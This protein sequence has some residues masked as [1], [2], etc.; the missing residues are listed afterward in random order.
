MQKLFDEDTIAAISTAV[1]ESGIG[2]IKISGPDALKIADKV[3]RSPGGKKRLA[4]VPT[5]T[6]HYGYIVEPESEQ[7]IDEIL[8]SVMLA[9]KTYTA[10]D[11]VEINCHGGVLV[12]TKVLDAV[13]KAGARP[14]EPGEFTKRAFLNGR[15]DLTGAEAV[16]DV[17]E[18]KNQFALQ[19]SVSQVRGSLYSKIEQIRGEMIYQSAHIEACLDN[20]DAMS[21]DDYLD[22]FSEKV[23][24]WTSDLSHLL[25]TSDSGRLMQEG[26]RTVIVGKPNAGKSSLLNLLLGEDRAIVT[27]IA[28]TTRDVLTETVTIGGMTLN[29][30]DTAGIRDTEDIVEKIGVQRARE[31]VE[32]ADLILYLI[33][34]STYIDMEDREIMDLIRGKKVIILQNKTDLDTVTDIESIRKAL[35]NSNTEDKDN[36]SKYNDISVIPFSAKEKTGLDQLIDTLKNLFFGGKLSFNDQIVIT[37]ARHKTLLA[38]ALESLRQLQKSI[39][40]VMPEDFYTVDLMSAYESLGEI[41]GQEIGDDLADE[42]FSRFCMGK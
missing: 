24:A 34:S 21:F 22:E 3:Y 41:T 23:K 33:D 10:E 38:K 6:I 17:I 37:N 42:I 11:V 2:I 13:I 8:V 18:S 15:I 7:I 1:S 39:D 36:I 9:P 30:T 16:M 32:K 29:I 5:H 35:Q 19:N 4:H 31:A 26:I 20:P 25:S 40:D 28:G 14:A 27:P 12:V